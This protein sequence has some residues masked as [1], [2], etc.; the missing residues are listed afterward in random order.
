M[1]FVFLVCSHLC[2]VEAPAAEPVDTAEGQGAFMGMVDRS[3]GMLSQR[4]EALSQ[5]FDTFFGGDRIYQESSGSYLKIGAAT[6]LQEG[7]EL[8]FSHILR[9]K[10]VL[11]KT[12]E[13]L[14]LLIEAD[15]EVVT[16]QKESDRIN[17]T[18]GERGRGKS[19]T[20]LRYILAQT[21]SWGL[22][23]DA[24]VKLRLPLDPFARIRAGWIVPLGEAWLFRLTEKVFIYNS[25]GLGETTRIDFDRTIHKDD[26][27][28]FSTEATW[29]EKE[30]GNF[31]LSQNVVFYQT[32]DPRN[33]LAYRVGVF[34]ATEPTFEASEYVVDVRY[35]RGVYKDW[36]FF[37][38]TPGVAFRDEHD[39]G[40]DFSFRV[41]FEALFGDK[42]ID[43]VTPSALR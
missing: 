3:H 26:L 35:R 16:S 27:L 42:Y 30:D 8:D 25:I 10:L 36:L 41:G 24:G 14:R 23:A 39:Y 6:L 37:D 43:K 32:I 21:K 22:D 15:D 28:R 29:H 34:A 38:L 33:S 17:E 2:V 40:P 31:Q 12:R 5:R 13:R 1:L 19:S 9:L 11:P 18:S 4:V 20:A 7:G